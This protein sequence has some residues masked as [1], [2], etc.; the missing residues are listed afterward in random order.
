[1]YVNGSPYNCIYIKLIYRNLTILVS[2]QVIYDIHKKE[3]IKRH[4]Q[5]NQEIKT[6]SLKN[7]ALDR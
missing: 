2:T 5:E 6:R 7:A 1:M 3:W 4:E